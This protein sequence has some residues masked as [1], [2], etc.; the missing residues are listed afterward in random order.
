MYSLN[1]GTQALS[2]TMLQKPVTG[3]EGQNGLFASAARDEQA[4]TLTVKIVNTSNVAQAVSLRFKG[5]RKG[6]KLRGISRTTLHSDN[7]D[8]DNSIEQPSAVIPVE[9]AF[10]FEGEA[11]QTEIPPQTF[12][13]Y[14]FEG[15]ESP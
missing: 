15:K 1:K 9:Q 14:K 2:L 5:L 3:A 4:K 8:S 10:S 13:V 12:A 11:F 6:E 7:P